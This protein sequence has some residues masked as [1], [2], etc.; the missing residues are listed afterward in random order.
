MWEQKQTNI[1]FKLKVCVLEE[2]IFIR[3][4]FSVLSYVFL[5]FSETFQNHYDTFPIKYS[6]MQNLAT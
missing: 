4:S 6:D 1:F 3:A 2:D 5:Y